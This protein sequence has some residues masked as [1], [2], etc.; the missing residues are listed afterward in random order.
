M[1]PASGIEVTPLPI[2]YFEEKSKEARN[3]ATTYR[4]NNAQDKATIVDLQADFLEGQDRQEHLKQSFDFPEDYPYTTMGTSNSSSF[5]FNDKC[6]LFREYEK[7]AEYCQK[8]LKYYEKN[9]NNKAAITGYAK[10]LDD[11]CKCLNEV[12]QELENGNFCF[13]TSANA[14][15]L[16]AQS[17]QVDQ[18]LWNFENLLS[19]SI[20]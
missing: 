3:L 15:K 11:Y 16:L 5:N 12:S 6:S 2:S 13:D 1:E 9:P 4:L 17:K 14:K 19:C 8:F 10:N 7:G 18:D 20:S